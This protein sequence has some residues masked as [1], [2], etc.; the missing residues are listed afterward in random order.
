MTC[1]EKINHIQIIIKRIV[2]STFFAII[3]TEII[4][5]IRFVFYVVYI[6]VYFFFRTIR[7]IKGLLTK[8]FI[9]QEFMEYKKGLI[10]FA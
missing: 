4:A 10:L 7:N 2:K 5:I 3:R 9:M 1:Y 6:K 8:D